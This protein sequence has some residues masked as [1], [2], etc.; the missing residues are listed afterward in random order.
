MEIFSQ[1]HKRARI[2]SNSARVLNGITNKQQFGEYWSQRNILIKQFYV[3][4]VNI[5]HWLSHVGASKFREFHKTTYIDHNEIKLEMKMHNWKV[6][7]CFKIVINS[8][9]KVLYVRCRSECG[10]ICIEEKLH[11]S[12]CCTR[13]RAHTHVN[14]LWKV[15]QG[16]GD[17]GCLQGVALGDLEQGVRET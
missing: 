5:N 7:S 14:Y 9:K 16:L 11:F 17:S 3:S 1:H 4:F 12:F 15:T 6:L 10:L 13:A 2:P 8:L